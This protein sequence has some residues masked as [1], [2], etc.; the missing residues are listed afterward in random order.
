MENDR[1]NEPVSDHEKLVQLV[2]ATWETVKG[3]T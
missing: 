1:I 2:D 3:V